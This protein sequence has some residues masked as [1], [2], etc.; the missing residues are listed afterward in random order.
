MLHI[1][2]FIPRVTSHVVNICCYEDRHCEAE[3]VI[4]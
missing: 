2:L 3:G 4:V 1:N